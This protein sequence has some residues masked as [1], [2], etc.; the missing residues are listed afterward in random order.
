MVQDKIHEKYGA[1]WEYI[2]GSML[3][4]VSKVGKEGAD[5]SEDCICNSS[6]DLDRAK[7]MLNIYVSM[8]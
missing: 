5:V 1:F 4:S 7:G 2:V 3:Y 6:A 8:I